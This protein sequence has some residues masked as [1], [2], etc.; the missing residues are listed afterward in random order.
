M[1]LELL[2]AEHEGQGWQLHFSWA[3]LPGVPGVQIPRA[4][5]GQEILLALFRD[6]PGPSLQ[7]SFLAFHSLG[8]PSPRAPLR[9]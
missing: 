9:P 4:F 2:R 1:L 8:I 7:G 3:W 6:R 5:Y